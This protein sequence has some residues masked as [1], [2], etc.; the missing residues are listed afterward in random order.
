MSRYK[1]YYVTEEFKNKSGD[2]ECLIQLLRITWDGDL[3]GKSARDKWVEKGYAARAD[4]FQIIT[5]AGIKHL[6]NIGAIR[7]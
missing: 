7:C 6:N 1:T 2:I 4:G 5:A 3:I